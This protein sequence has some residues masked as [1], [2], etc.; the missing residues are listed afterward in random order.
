VAPEA[1]EERALALVEAVLVGAARVALARAVEPEAGEILAAV[2][3]L[4]QALEVVEAQA[5]V[6]VEREPDPAG[7]QVAK[8]GAENG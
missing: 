1:A 6:P 4:V 2:L 3:E 5:S 7:R 8:D